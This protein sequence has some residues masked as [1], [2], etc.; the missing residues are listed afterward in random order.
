MAGSS[1]IEKITIPEKF[2][3]RWTQEEADAMH[4]LLQK[5]A[6]KFNE[7]VSKADDHETRITDLGG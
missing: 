3:P 7:L 1:G 2:G 5:I 6:T 4:V